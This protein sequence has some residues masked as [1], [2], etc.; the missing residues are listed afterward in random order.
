MVPKAMYVAKAQITFPFNEKSGERKFVTVMSAS[1]TA[2]YR[3]KGRNFT[4]GPIFFRW[5][6]TVPMVK[7]EKASQIF[8]TKNTIP[9]IEAESPSVSV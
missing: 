2:V 3:M 9:A 4:F 8:V 5:S 6:T 7:S 1:G